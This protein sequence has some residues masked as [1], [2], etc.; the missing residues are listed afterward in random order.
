M[1]VVLRDLT[2]TKCFTFIDHILNFAND[3]LEHDRR[4][5][6]VLQRYDRANLKLQ[7][8][9]CAFPEPKK[10][11]LGYIVSRDGISSSPTN[12]QAILKYTVPK[13]ELELITVTWATKHYKCYI[14]DDGSSPC[15]IEI[16]T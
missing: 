10:E 3:I 7:P 6:H 14:F 12:V 9:K 11:Y 5:E 1:D 8:G 2:G 15:C 4:L 13:N 16:L